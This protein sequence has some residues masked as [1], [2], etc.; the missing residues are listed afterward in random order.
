M[1]DVTIIGVDLPQKVFR[2]AIA[3][4]DGPVLLRKK[5]PRP[6]FVRFMVDRPPDGRR[7]EPRCRPGSAP[8]ARAYRDIVERGQSRPRGLAAQTKT[9]SLI[10]GHDLKAPFTVGCMSV[11][12]ARVPVLARDFPLGRALFRKAGPHRV[13]AEV[14]IGQC[15]ADIA[16]MRDQPEL[17]PV[18][19]L[20]LAGSAFL[21][22]LHQ[23]RRRIQRVF[24][25]ALGRK[26]INLGR[27]GPHCLP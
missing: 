19:G 18:P 9:I 23:V 14:R 17:C 11:Q 26:E 7:P 20:H 12:D 16:T 3:A 24:G 22:P 2:V 6:N 15:A 10:G 21:V 4:A 8:A 1:G 25:I 13:R 27:G 5:L